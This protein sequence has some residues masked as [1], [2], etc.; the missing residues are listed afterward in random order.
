MI[1]LLT[2]TLSI[3]ISLASISFAVDEYPAIKKK[4][5][6]Q[7]EQN[8]VVS[9]PCE[10][11][12][13]IGQWECA[14]KKMEIADK[15]LNATYKVLIGMLQDGFWPNGVEPK[16]DLIEAQRLWIKYR[17]ANCQLVGGISGGAPEWR[18]AYYE[19]CRVEMTE[20]RTEELQK[21]IEEHK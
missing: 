17:D 5:K 10:S 2:I 11:T 7:Y 8:N 4:S 3:L 6:K 19:N 14:Q 15:K 1:R 13:G 9:D 18:S 21:Y 20:K 16:K 12:S